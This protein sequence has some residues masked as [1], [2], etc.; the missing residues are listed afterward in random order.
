MPAWN[1]MPA[2]GLS[3]SSVQTTASEPTGLHVEM[4]GEGFSSS[5]NTSF[6]AKDV[7]VLYLFNGAHTD[8]HRVSDTPDRIDPAGLS[9]AARLAWRFA[10]FAADDPER[11]Q[12][13]KVAAPASKGGNATRSGRP[14][15]GTIPDF[16]ER[17]EPGVLIT[18]VMPGSPAEK[19]GLKAGDVVLRLG[20]RKLMNLQDMQYAL[21]ER[22][23][24]DV[25]ELE[26][27]RDGKVPVVSVTL[28]ERR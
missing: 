27:A 10:R 15:L 4:S 16:A 23:P 11:L 5:D 19:A 14:S 25:L 26:Y 1:A 12:V 8:Y 9:G 17:S 24:G 21:V 28:A 13:M 7:P 18:G 20:D 2:Y 22:R 3:E 6:Y